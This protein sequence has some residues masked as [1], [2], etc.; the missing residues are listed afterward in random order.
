MS[1]F[2]LL[3]NRVKFPIILMYLN[4]AILKNLDNKWLTLKI[5]L[6]NSKIIPNNKDIKKWYDY[7]IA[8]HK[9]LKYFFNQ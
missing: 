7:N 5:I 3:E 2:I 6:Q 8:L 9:L 4:T 1:K